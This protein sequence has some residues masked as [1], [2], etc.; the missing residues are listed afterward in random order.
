MRDEYR[1]ALGLPY[2]RELARITT[3]LSTTVCLTK[4]P[5]QCPIRAVS[6]ARKRQSRGLRSAF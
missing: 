1:L 5:A 2:A 6:R 3:R 4:V